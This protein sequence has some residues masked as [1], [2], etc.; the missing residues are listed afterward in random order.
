MR[1]SQ[2]LPRL[3]LMTD[4]RQGA[5]LLDAVRR[6]PDGAGIVFRHYRL[7]ETA[8]RA[9]FDRV[10]EAASNALLLLAGPADQAR[11]WGA[12]GSHGPGRGEGLRSAPAHD[13][14]AIR[15]AERAGAALVFLSPV[16]ATRSHP[17][18][19][20][21][22]LARFAW[23]ARRTALPVIALGGMDPARGRRLASFGAYGWAA[24][25]AWG[26]PSA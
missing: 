26:A 19:R 17:E 23:L 4:E 9:L 10:R 3:W 16:Y 14:G 6:L 8:R 15:A 5:G 7:E 2:L 13:Q 12:D 22:G 18:A 21:L 11:S 25:D 1:A 20:P 24:I